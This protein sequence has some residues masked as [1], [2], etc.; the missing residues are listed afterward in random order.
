MNSDKLAQRILGRLT[1]PTDLSHLSDE[2]LEAI[3]N[4][5]QTAAETEQ[6]R[7]ISN[8]RT[9]ELSKLTD[10]ELQRIIDGLPPL[11]AE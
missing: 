5:P 6:V 2:E 1:P 3:I 10:A 8:G 4:A 9:S 7:Y 11:Q